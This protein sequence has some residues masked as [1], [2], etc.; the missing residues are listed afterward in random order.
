MEAHLLR[1]KLGR[2]VLLLEDRPEVEEWL[3]DNQLLMLEVK[4][5]NHCKI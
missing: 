1:P 5:R 4:V 3:P 2:Q